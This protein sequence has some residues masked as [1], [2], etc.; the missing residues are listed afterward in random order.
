M[1]NLKFGG[2]YE[3]SDFKARQVRGDN[4]PVF[5][6]QDNFRLDG[7]FDPN[8]GSEGFSLTDTSFLADGLVSFDDIGNPIPG[9][10][11]V[12]V[13]DRNAIQAYGAQARRSL[14]AAGVTGNREA[15][16]TSEN[17]YS[18]YVQAELDLTE[19]LSAIVG[20]RA[21][22]VNVDTSFL[23]TN[24]S[25]RIDAQALTIDDFA[26][27]TSILPRLQFNYRPNSE[28]VVRAA[29]S[30]AVARPEIEDLAEFTVSGSSDDTGIDL[31]VR[32]PNPGL[33]PAYSHNFDLSSEYF[34]DN[35]VLGIGTFYKRINNFIFNNEGSIAGANGVNQADV[36]S[37]IQGLENVQNL[38]PETFEVSFA[39][40]I[41]GRPA[42][43]YGVEFNLIYQ[44]E[45]LLPGFW[46]GF[47]VYANLT[48]Q[49]TETDVDIDTFPDNHP[50]RPGETLVSTLPFFA[51]PDYVGNLALTY[52][53]HG[54]DAS[55]S[56]SFQAKQ[57]ADLQ[58]HLNLH[59]Y[60]Q[61][62][63]SLDLNVQYTLP[64][65]QKNQ[66]TA[67]FAVN[68]L[69]NNGDRPINHQTVGESADVVD[70]IEFIGREFRFGVRA[71]F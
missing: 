16:D 13:Y 70:L 52:N 49:E 36:L 63:D 61:G 66:Y 14:D 65:G 7:T 71:T 17:I 51:A 8:A 23:T 54:L 67:F 64:V 29:Y 12:F 44:F 39:Q 31:S 34:F 30:T 40:P 4:G 37:I 6:G 55:L 21:E 43:V 69:N 1:R 38:N 59:E 22:H 35:G 15:L 68:D 48:L 47:G 25:S 11:S 41:N 62:Y 24:F 46:S 9:L 19:N 50:T 18:A 26:S 42:D 60:L 56:Y 53:K 20:A 57:L 27:Y 33:D 5:D 28:W 45:D 2:K 58:D 3:R 10:N 32:L